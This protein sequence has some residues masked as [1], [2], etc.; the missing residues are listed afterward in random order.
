M[1]MT[2]PGGSLG[3]SA[4]ANHK[5]RTE[6]EQQQEEEEEEEEEEASYFTSSRRILWE[7]KVLDEDE[8]KGRLIC[9]L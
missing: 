5:P 9:V 1:E 4:A 7:G 2:P 3:R 8:A 6:T